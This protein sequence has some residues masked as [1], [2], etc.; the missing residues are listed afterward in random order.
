MVAGEEAVEERHGVR[1]GV[2]L[3]RHVVGRH[4]G[5]EGGLGETTKGGIGK[6]G[7]VNLRFPLPSVSMLKQTQ[8]LFKL[9]DS[10][11]FANTPIRHSPP[12]VSSLH[13]GLLGDGVVVR[14]E[15]NLAYHTSSWCEII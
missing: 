11:R 2:H 14:G 1:G 5:R 9:H 13:R 10:R 8:L 15:E 3:R 7:I 6:G 4:A 12:F